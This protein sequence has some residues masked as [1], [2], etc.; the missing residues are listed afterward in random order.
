[1]SQRRKQEK[2]QLAMRLLLTTELQIKHISN[3]VGYDSPSKF[4]ATFKKKY[5]K[6]PSAYR[7][8]SPAS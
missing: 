2:M 8:D 5:G 1:M 6:L 4:T 3:Q 7:P